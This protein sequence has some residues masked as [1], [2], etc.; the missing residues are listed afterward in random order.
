VIDACD[1]CLRRTDLLVGL[2]GAIDVEWKRRDRPRSVLAL[3]DEALLTLSADGRA[4]SRYAAFAP[5]HARARVEAVGMQAA[6]RCSDDY[7]ASLRALTDPPAILHALGRLGQVAPGEESAVAI[8]GARRATEYGGEVARSLARGIASAGLSVVSGMAMGI[9]SV[10]HQ[11]ALD[12]GGHTVAVLA[13]GADIPYP[14]HK[15][16]L[17]R[18]ILAEGGAVVS[19]WPPG[20]GAHRWSFV[21]R[22]RLIAALA[23]ITVVVEGT[24]RS[25][26]LTTAGFATEAGR[27]VAAVPGPV[28]SRLS[29]GPNALLSDGAALIADAGDVLD[30]MLGPGGRERVAAR[31]V[32]LEPGLAALLEGI[33]AGRQTPGALVTA[34]RGVEDV[35]RGLTELELHGLVRRCFDGRYIRAAA[36]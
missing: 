2:F 1:D 33:E 28:T 7:P 5:A 31:R 8:V 36:P 23:G 22:N 20:A 21:A 26:S 15:A 11:G 29:T 27:I 24:V 32:S 12:A 13:G 14:G 3:E 4:E 30:L 25:G 16:H 18:R 9:D 34:N 19:E 10:A 6:C 35:L 17:H